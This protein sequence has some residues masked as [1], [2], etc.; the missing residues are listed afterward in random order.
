[1]AEILAR[2]ARDANRH[3]GLRATGGNDTDSTKRHGGSEKHSDN[4]DHVHVLAP[5]LLSNRSKF[6]AERQPAQL[7]PY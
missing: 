3:E 5:S 4:C 6:L 1:M 2:P 7:V